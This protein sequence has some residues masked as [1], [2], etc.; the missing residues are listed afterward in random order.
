MLIKNK[1]SFARGL[2]MSAV[3]VAILVVMFMP[4]FNGGNAFRAADKLF[5]T[6]SKGSTYYIPML[7]ENAEPHRNAEFDGAITVKKALAEDVRKV[8]TTAGAEVG[9]EDGQLQVAVTMGTLYDAALRDSNDMFENQG[10]TVSERYGLPEKRVLFAW[11]NAL[12]ALGK[13]LDAEERFKETAYIGELISRGIEVGYNYYTV[14]AQKA[15]DRWLILTSALIFYV[16]YT[17]WWG[18]AV[19]F[20]F[21]GIGLQLTAGH[22]KES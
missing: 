8:L 10:K 2:L 5:N 4:I 1:K 16:I 11:R 22:K 17:L 6:I 13:A 19:Y 20:L 3:F 18:F 15:A 21:E 9:G 14:T 12:K 7:R